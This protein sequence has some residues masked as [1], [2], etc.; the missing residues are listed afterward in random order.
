MKINPTAAQQAN[1]CG[2][3]GIRLALG[4]GWLGVVCG[5]AVSIAP[6]RRQGDF[7]RVSLGFPR[8][9]DTSDGDVFALSWDGHLVAVE[10]V[11]CHQGKRYS[12][13]ESIGRS[14]PM[15]GRTG[16][17]SSER[18]Q[19]R[20]FMSMDNIWEHDGIGIA[21]SGMCIVFTVLMLISLFISQLPRCL[22]LI[23]KVV[24]EK[25]QDQ[26]DSVSAVATPSRSEE[27]SRIAAI[28]YALYRSRRARD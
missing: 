28:G 11:A 12:E 13:S 18:V 3:W 25:V 9:R 10:S 6:G 27:M 5:L 7:D 2:E 23:D 19:E 15:L 16:S 17:E 8:T 4:E 24:P 22:S 20:H 21:V 26:D 1:L 14:R